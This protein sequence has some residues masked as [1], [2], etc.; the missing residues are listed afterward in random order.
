VLQAVRK[1]KYTLS[2]PKWEHI[3]EDSKDFIRHLL[4]YNPAKRMTAEQ[5]LKHPWLQRAKG[6][7]VHHPLDP[8]ILQNLRDFSKFSTFKR[9]AL[10]AIAF[11]MSAQ[12]IR[13]L[14]EQFMKLDKDQSGFV[15]LGE[16]LEVVS[17]SGLSKVRFFWP[18]LRF[19]L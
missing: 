18:E 7:S 15:S 19:L 6:E 8:E 9:A 1:G 11:S 4:V 10:E 16:F 5:A 13:H 12:S 2:G 3:S 17:S 14:R